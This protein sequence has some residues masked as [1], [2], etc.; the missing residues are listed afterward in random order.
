MADPVLLS[1]E[2]S[3]QF[4]SLDHGSGFIGRKRELSE[5]L[6]ALVGAPQPPGPISLITGSPGIGKTRLASELS[7]HA[8]E[9]NFQVAWGYG[10]DEAGAPPYWPWT[11]VVRQIQGLTRGTDL[12]T[13]VLEE[14]EGAD[15]F[16]LFDATAAMVRSAVAERPLL[17]VLDDL[18]NADSPTLLLTRFIARQVQ[19]CPVMIVATARPEEDIAEHLEALG[20]LGREV[21]LRGLDVDEVS[22]LIQDW[23]MGSA[24]HAVT[25]GNPLYVEQV[26][27]STQGQNTLSLAGNKESVDSVSG[28]RAAVRARIEDLTSQQVQA[29]QAAAILGLRPSISD[30]AELVSVAHGISKEIIPSLVDSLLEAE[31]LTRNQIGNLEFS[32]PLIAEE[33]SR[34]VEESL[35]HELHGTAADLIGGDQTRMD[36][37]A[38]HLLNA[39]PG[40]RDEAVAACIVAA[41]SATKALAHED[42]AA[43]YFSAL[44]A[45]ADTTERRQER[46]DLLMMLGESLWRSARSDEAAEVFE[47]GWHVATDLGDAKSLSRAALR[48]GISYYFVE[49][50]EPEWRGRV[51]TALAQQTEDESSSKAKL[52]AQLAALHLDEATDQDPRVLARR[53][54]EMARRVADP[55]ALGYALVATQVSDLGPRTLRQRISGANEILA[56]ARESHDYRLM[57]HGRFLLM[58]ALL[59]NGDVRRID[60]ELSEQYELVELLGEPRFTRF[61][62]WFRAMRSLLD[63]DSDVAE[64]LAEQCLTI[65][66]SIGDPDR[67]AVYGGQLGVARWMQGRM[68]EVEALFLDLRAAEPEE[69]LWTAVMAWCWATQGQIA[70][71]RG[72]LADMPDLSN[73]PR[74][75]NWLIT[76][77]ALAEAVAVVGDDEGAA[78]VWSELLPYADRVVPIGMGAA[79]WG[80]VARPLGLLALRLGHIEEGLSHLNS[81]IEICAR[82]GARPWLVEAQLE[83]A[84]ALIAHRTSDPQIRPLILEAAAAAEQLDLPRFIERAS[85]MQSLLVGRG[86]SAGSTPEAPGGAL[87]AIAV[88]AGDS[89][90]SDG[91]VDGVGT[92]WPRVSVMGTF[93]VVTS[94]GVAAKWTSRKARELLKILV[95]RRGVPIVRESLMD[96]LWPGED[97]GRL[98]NRLSVAM[99]TVRR[100]LDPGRLFES[101]DILSAAADTV[102]LRTDLVHVDVEDFLARSERILDLAR[103][104]NSDPRRY[105][106]D[107]A[108][109][110]NE[111][112]RS[113]RGEALPDEPHAEWAVSLRD[114]V[115]ARYVAV[116]RF[117]ASAAHDASDHLRAGEAYRRILD[118]D[119]YDEV[120]HMGLIRS[121]RSMSAHGQADIAYSA[122][123]SRMNELSV[124]ARAESEYKFV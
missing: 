44:E 100:A 90:A 60:A 6:Q 72:A 104:D 68:D 32:H 8:R 112:L 7:T 117:V 93:E 17:I 81:A 76:M 19:D 59:E 83:L 50:P 111:L 78:R 123:V 36:E 47:A 107:V 87:A 54:L 114:E 121:F 95:A 66:E 88:E 16:E 105:R 99:S 58:G 31:I 124:P 89:S 110:A 9:R 39:G 55:Q 48:S 61:V 25:A 96:L 80:T 49:F 53:S 3:V 40:R 73:I 38:H 27:R 45:L 20:R 28:L 18:H 109:Q 64:E 15:R 23:K 122:Y 85:E 91:G 94:D 14:P 70:A 5:L 51:E 63:G 37:R 106:G 57:L 98:G 4:S 42:G 101:D 30:I 24:V 13:L 46:L 34:M 62:L 86:T 33:S 116:A 92:G 118:V 119:P 79:A 113:Y 41:K 120:A 35:R 26:V 74:S 67:Y 10:P 69:P 82:L 1:G 52:L 115:R 11:Q 12:A 103:S 102:V 2:R 56:C 75:L 43:L 22:Q 65:S 77:S 108:D 21:R 97:P 84:G 71:A 29:L